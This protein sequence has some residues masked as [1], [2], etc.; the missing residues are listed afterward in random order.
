M[1]QRL[2]ENS[3][4]I[5]QLRE[6]LKSSITLVNNRAAALEGTVESLQT[7]VSAHSD[8]FVRLDDQVLQLRKDVKTLT[9]RNEDHDAKLRR[10]NLRISGVKEGRET[11]KIPVMFMADLLKDALGLDSPP[12]LDSAYRT[13]RARQGD[14]GPPRAYLIKCHYY[15]EREA[16]LRK[17]AK[18]KELTTPE[19]DRIWIQADYTQAVMNQ[20]NAFREVKKILRECDGVE[21]GLRYPAVLIVNTKS[22]G[23]RHTF[24][25]PVKAKGFAMSLPGA[26]PLG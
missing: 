14:D 4:Q 20:R 12:T 6:E 16:I 21:Y 8:N 25:D 24:T 22:D 26:A 1:L 10:S 23:Q 5:A 17:A 9:V 15:Q 7:A 13:L 19:G 2:D 11:G 18:T 3:R